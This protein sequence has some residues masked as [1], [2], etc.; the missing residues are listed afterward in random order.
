MNGILIV[1]K[2]AGWTS[3]DVVAKVRRLTGIRRVG[4]SGTLDPLAT[5]VLV[6]CLGQAV[7]ITEY[8][9]GHAKAYRATITL[10]V[11]TDTYDAHG[12]VVATQPVEV[13][14]AELR[15][16]LKAFTG[17]IQQ[18][19]PMYSAIKR[20]GQ[21]LYKLARQGVEVERAPRTV[22]IHSIDL[23]AFAPPNLTIDVRCSS[24]TYIRS[25]A[26]D[27]GAKLGCGAHLSALTRTA[28][29]RFELAQAVSIETLEQAAA[30]GSLV[31]WLRPIDLAL[32]ELA[33][34]TLSESDAARVR[35][36]MAVPATGITTYTGS[37]VRV[38]NPSG[39]L[40]GLMKHDRE[41]NELRPE[42]VFNPN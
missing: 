34:V 17:V 4:H 5:G 6:I 30:V 41:R 2:P 22:T 26:H 36:G 21:Q 33:S 38:Y 10:G 25:L 20:A 8:I 3:F 39:E 37:L 28:V 24:G 16:A 15:D 40:I 42:K 11:E 29:G 13:S 7:R 32:T 31:D 12:Q 35:H 23:I 18:V 1:N 27:L 14:E 19:P 9:V